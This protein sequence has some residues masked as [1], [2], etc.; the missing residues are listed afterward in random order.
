MVVCVLVLLAVCLRYTVV[1]TRTVWNLFCCTCA[2]A[3]CT[4]QFFVVRVCT[5]VHLNRFSLACTSL[6]RKLLDLHALGADCE[7]PQFCDEVE[8]YLGEQV[9]VAWCFN[10]CCIM[11]FMVC[12]IVWCMVWWCYVSYLLSDAYT[13]VA[14][15]LSPWCVEWWVHV[16]CM[17]SVSVCCRMCCLVC[18]TVLTLCELTVWGVVCVEVCQKRPSKVSKET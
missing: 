17:V 14:G 1:Q 5:R 2:C 11:C 9:G 8:E 10:V 13:C 18:S 16:C 7:D 12:C 4:F 3:V 15:C 6:S